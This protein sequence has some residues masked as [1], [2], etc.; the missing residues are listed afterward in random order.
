MAPRLLESPFAYTMTCVRWLYIYTK[1]I[2]IHETGIETGATRLESRN[3]PTFGGEE[4]ST[5]GDAPM[6]G[7]CYHLRVFIQCPLGHLERWRR[8]GLPASSQL[9]FGDLHVHGVRHGINMDNV[10]VL[11]ESDRT[12]Y[13]CLRNDVADDESM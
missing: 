4:H 1:G 6:T 10:L 8:P 5:V 2:K 13:L 11:N 7:V 3:T 9:F 12:A